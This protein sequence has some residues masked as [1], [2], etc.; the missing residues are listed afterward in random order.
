MS[1]SLFVIN[2][3]KLSRDWRLLFGGGES[4]SSTLPRNIAPI[5][6]RWEGFLEK[7]SA[8]VTAASAARGGRR[9]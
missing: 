6:R 7:R 9:A 2:Y 5:V 1:D 4:Y 3:W 8:A